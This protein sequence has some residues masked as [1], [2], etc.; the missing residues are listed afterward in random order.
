MAG[1]RVGSA[2]GYLVALAA[3][4]SAPH[5]VPAVGHTALAARRGRG[6]TPGPPACG[7]PPSC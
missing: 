5:V 7:W 4:A 6:P 3:V 2:R 1:L